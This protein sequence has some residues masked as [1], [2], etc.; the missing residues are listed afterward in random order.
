M[1]NHYSIYTSWLPDQVATEA[2]NKEPARFS[3]A[4]ANL[5]KAVQYSQEQAAAGNP[6]AWAAVLGQQLDDVK[7]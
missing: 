1:P 4:V 7:T 2:R 5:V 6:N 3:A